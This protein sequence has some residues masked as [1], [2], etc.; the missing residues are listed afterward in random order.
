MW[1][2]MDELMQSRRCC[3]RRPEGPPAPPGGNER[4]KLRMAST[5]AGGQTGAGAHGSGVGAKRG[6]S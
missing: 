6:V 3:G 5:S 1:G 4:I 2:L